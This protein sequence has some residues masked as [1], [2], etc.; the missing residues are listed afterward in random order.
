MQGLRWACGGPSD[1]RPASR[2]YARFISAQ[3]LRHRNLTPARRISP[4]TGD[5]CM[6]DFAFVALGFAL[7][8]LTAAY[9]YGLVRL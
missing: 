1:P 2:T 5:Y 3:A 4:A 7:I 6:L 8:A 9:A